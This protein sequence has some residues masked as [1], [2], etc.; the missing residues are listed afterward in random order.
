MYICIYF[1]ARLGRPGSPPSTSAFRWC[2]CYYFCLY[3]IQKKCE[4][5]TLTATA[6]DFGWIS[7]REKRAVGSLVTIWPGRNC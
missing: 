7:A 6:V 3:T 4:T 2:S 1:M 5:L